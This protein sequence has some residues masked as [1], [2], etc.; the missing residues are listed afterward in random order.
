MAFINV[1]LSPGMDAGLDVLAPIAPQFFI[2][3]MVNKPQDPIVHAIEKEKATA[4]VMRNAREPVY[5][6]DAG[7]PQNTHVVSTLSTELLWAKSVTSGH[8]H[9]VRTPRVL[10]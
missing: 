1:A 9:S 8:R 10:A 7:C 4:P 2:P 6:R 3:R 5:P